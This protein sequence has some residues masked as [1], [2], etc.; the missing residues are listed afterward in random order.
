[1][2]KFTLAVVALALISGGVGCKSRLSDPKMDCSGGYS[3][4]YYRCDWC[5]E[6]C[7]WTRTGVGAMTQ[8]QHRDWAKDFV[9]SDDQGSVFCTLRCKTAFE[10]SDGVQEDRQR[11]IHQDGDAR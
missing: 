9:I 1:M 10:A 3:N 7:A 11:V 2:R 5:K 8:E 6:V 4:W